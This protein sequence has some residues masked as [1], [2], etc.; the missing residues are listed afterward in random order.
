MVP[1]PPRRQVTTRIDAG[2]L[3]RQPHWVLPHVGNDDHVGVTDPPRN[4][5][6]G[7][8]GTQSPDREGRIRVRLRDSALVCGGLGSPAPPP[9]I[10]PP[11]AMLLAGR[12]PYELG[13][14]GREVTHNGKVGFD[15]ATH[16]R[17]VDIE[18]HHL[19]VWRERVGFADHPVI[20]AEAEAQHEVGPLDASVGAFGPVHARHTQRQAMVRS[21]RIE[22]QQCGDHRQIRPLRQ[23]AHHTRDTRKHDPSPHHDDGS[24]GLIQK[25]G[26]PIESIDHFRGQ[27]G[28]LGANV[29]RKIS[30]VFA[31]V[32]TAEVVKTSDS[33][34]PRLRRPT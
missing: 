6:D 31:A 9:Q 26:R 12:P 14:R 16:G 28:G 15:G 21:K 1:S 11:L 20:E 24:I 22:S 34:R 32:G 30:G 4:G 18:M 33:T 3:L 7:L 25:C 10:P 17:L 29:R 13:Q 27:R 19:G 8:A 2:E 5:A 23:H